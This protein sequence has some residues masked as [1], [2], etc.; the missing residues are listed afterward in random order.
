MKDVIDYIWKL[1]ENSKLRG[2]QVERVLGNSRY[3]NA[4]ATLFEKNFEGVE[5]MKSYLLIERAE[6]GGFTPKE[7]D[8]YQRAI[9]DVMTFMEAC[10]AT[11]K[12]KE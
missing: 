2:S 7:Y 1:V 12:N 3:V 10:L 5:I 11:V 8:E 9:A 4:F 6:K